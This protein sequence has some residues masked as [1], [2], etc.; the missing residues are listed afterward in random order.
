MFLAPGICRRIT[1]RFGFPQYVSCLRALCSTS[2]LT[3]RLALVASTLLHADIL[4]NEHVRSYY[5]KTSDNGVVHRFW[6]PETADSVRSNGFRR[7][8]VC[9]RAEYKFTKPTGTGCCITARSHA[10]ALPIWCSS[11]EGMCVLPL[12]SLTTAQDLMERR[13]L[14]TLH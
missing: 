14:S 2:L 12:P 13:G 5:G 11:S 6:S 9:E 1:G 8:K 4:R 7:L 10:L 3:F